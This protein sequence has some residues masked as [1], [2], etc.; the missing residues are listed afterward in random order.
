MT[1]SRSL[2]LPTP[3]DTVVQWPTGWAV[4]DVVR[5]ILDAGDPRMVTELEPLLQGFSFDTLDKL[6]DLLR[7]KNDPKKGIVGLKED[8]IAHEAI[9]SELEASDACVARVVAVCEALVSVAT[10]TVAASMVKQPS[11]TA[12]TTVFR[13]QP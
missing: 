2:A 13:F 3:P 1:T 6:R 9:V 4:E 7:Q 10:G 11:S 8:V 12:A 5:W